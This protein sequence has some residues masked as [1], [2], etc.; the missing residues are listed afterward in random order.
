[1]KYAPSD[2]CEEMLNKMSK[3]YFDLDIQLYH[4]MFCKFNLS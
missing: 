1:M 2:F 3:M 4:F